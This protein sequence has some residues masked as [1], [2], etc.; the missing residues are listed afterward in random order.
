MITVVL[1]VLNQYKLTNDLLNCISKN[2]EKP[3][4]IILIDNGST[5]PI[6]ELVNSHKNLNI[7]YVR[8]NENIGVNPSWNL[9]IMKSKTPVVSILNNDLLINNHFFKRIK[10]TMCDKDIG[11]CVPNTIPDMYYAM[12]CKYEPVKIGPCNKREGWAFTIKKDI[13]DKLGYIPKELN[14]TYGDDYIF[15]CARKLN[16][17]TVRI[18]NNYIFHYGSITTVQELKEKGKEFPDKNIEREIWLKIKHRLEGGEKNVI[19][20]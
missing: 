8:F 10:E 18:E 20:T 19:T 6:N 13:I 5:D 16:Y 12:T 1:P 17:R 7:R 9:G 11:I 2:E 3:E 4:E 15:H 14:R